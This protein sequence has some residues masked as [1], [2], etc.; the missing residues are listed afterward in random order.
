M[1]DVERQYQDFDT[2][3]IIQKWT[4]RGEKADFLGGFLHILWSARWKVRLSN[5]SAGVAA[6]RRVY[7]NACSD[8]QNESLVKIVAFFPTKNVLRRILE[9]PINEEVEDEVLI[10]WWNDMQKTLSQ[11]AQPIEESIFEEK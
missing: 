1:M 6:I 4:A 8:F 10:L 3:K 9:Q 2:V 11:G 5:D 7:D